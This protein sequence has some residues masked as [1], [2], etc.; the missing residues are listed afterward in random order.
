VNKRLAT[1]FGAYGVLIA[2][3]AFVLHGTALYAVLLLFVALMAKTL[4]AWKA[5]W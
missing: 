4:I 1:A 5:G 3:A 2:I